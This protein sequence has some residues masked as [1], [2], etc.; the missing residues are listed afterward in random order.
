MKLLFAATPLTGHLNPL[1]AI[2]R[3]AAERGDEIVMTCTEPFRARIEKAGFRFL[4]YVSKGNPEY[5]DTDL[6]AGPERYRHEFERRFL[7]GMPDQAL[8]LR[9]LIAAE[10]PDAIVAGSLFLG[11]LPLLLGDGERPPIVLCNVS[12]LFHDRPD[13]APVGF[14]L[15]PAADAAEGERYAAMAAQVDAGFTNPVR[16]YADDLLAKEGLPGLPASL[17]HSIV[18]LPDAF[19]QFTVPS[20]EYDYGVLPPHV[21]FVGALPPPVGTMPLPEW[22]DEIDGHRRVVLVTQGTL[23]NQN[24]D[25]LIEPTLRALADRDDLLVVATTGG[26]PVESLRAPLPGNARVS[27]FLP[28]GDLLPKVDVFVTNGGY[29]SVSMALEAGVPIVSAG[30]TE[31]KAEIGARIAWSGVGLNLAASEPTRESLHE[32]IATVLD[33]PRFRERAAEM[34]RE[35]ARYDTRREILGLIDGVRPRKTG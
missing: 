21:R 25:E 13:H 19:A 18:I 12:F 24:F 16:A 29:G 3:L 27:T 10:R 14:G 22:W 9:D 32:T 4:P 17:P 28:F 7:D 33:E 5:R 26:R 34:A 11:V 23:A 31:D 35:F 15:P 2:A 30:V 20:F 6:P 8:T 1:L